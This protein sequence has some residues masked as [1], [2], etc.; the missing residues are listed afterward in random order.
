MWVVNFPLFGFHGGRDA[1]HTHK[2]EA[3][4]GV[5]Q[6]MRGEQGERLWQRL[7]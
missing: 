5:N 2:L 3:T 6:I 4:H 7:S 1:V